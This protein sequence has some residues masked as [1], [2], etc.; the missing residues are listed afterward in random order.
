MGFCIGD[1]AGKIIG[2]VARICREGV[3]EEHTRAPDGGHP[4]GTG[5]ERL[6]GI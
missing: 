4:R 6:T 1:A 5:W 2:E 3:A